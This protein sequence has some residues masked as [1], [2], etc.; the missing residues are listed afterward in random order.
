MWCPPVL[1]EPHIIEFDSTGWDIMRSYKRGTFINDRPCS[2]TGKS[3][4]EWMEIEHRLLFMRDSAATKENR[5]IIQDEKVK[6]VARLLQLRG[7]GNR[8]FQSYS[9][10]LYKARVKYSPEYG[11]DIRIPNFGMQGSKRQLQITIPAMRFDIITITNIHP[12]KAP[13]SVHYSFR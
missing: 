2:M 6:D 4:H 11:A 5:I 7:L 13:T 10:Y 8:T 9:Y 12:Y 1:D 3:Q